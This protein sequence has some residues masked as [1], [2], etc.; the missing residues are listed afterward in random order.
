MKSKK[1][2][3]VYDPFCS[4]SYNHVVMFEDE[5][6][7]VVLI[8]T[9]RSVD[10]IEEISPTHLL[11]SSGP[12]DPHKAE[13]LANA[14]DRFKARIPILGVCLG[15]Q[16]MGLYFKSE[17]E[18]VSPMH[19]KASMVEHGSTGI[20]SGIPSPF[21][22]CRYHSWAISDTSICAESLRVTARSEDGV[23][24]GIQSVEF[25]RVVGVQFHPESLFKEHGNMIAQN[26]LS[27]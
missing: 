27:M 22:A 13:T 24:M 21:L 10:A 16:V 9:D 12:G 5:G 23:I 2:L 18:L 1:T 8:R 19:G 4:F 15:H 3:V 6:A 17:V 7:E 20:F 25:P 26:F 14:L 11:L